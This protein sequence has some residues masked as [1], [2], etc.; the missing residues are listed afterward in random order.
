V[1][2]DWVVSKDNP[3]FAKVIVNRVWADLMGRGLVEPVDDLRATN[4]PSN[5][6]L[7]EALA[8]DFRKNGH[9]LKKLLRTIATSSAYGL[10]SKTNARNAADTRN[11]SRHYRQRL[12]AEVLLDA[13]SD[14]TAVPETFSG[15]PAGSR[16]MELWTARAQSLF[17]DSFGRPD[18]NQDPPCERTPDTTVVQALH[19]MNSPGMHR[20]VTSDTGR[21]AKLA[22]SKLTPAEVVEELYSLCYGRRPSDEER[23]TCLAL[24][25]DKEVTRRQAVEDVLWALLN[26]PEFVFKN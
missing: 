10:S 1:L 19:L 13:V 17:L 5:G 26:T 3:T 24:F 23:R 21:A 16:A 8:E 12:R 15:M 2:A 4:P 18:P 11:H 14:V 7:L 25:A 22:A 20:K 6:P 9:D